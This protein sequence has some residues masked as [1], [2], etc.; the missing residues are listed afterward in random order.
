MALA[1]S[2]VEK[3][4]GV[5]RPKEDYEVDPITAVFRIALLSFLE[6]VKI[7][8]YNKAIFFSHGT[9]TEKGYRIMSRDS[10]NDLNALHGIIKV[11]LQI[12]PPKTET[13]Q[14]LLFTQCKLGLEQLK[15]TYSSDAEAGTLSRILD[16][17]MALIQAELDNSTGPIPELPRESVWTKEQLEVII[18]QLKVIIVCKNEQAKMKMIEGIESQL[19]AKDILYFEKITPAKAA[20]LPAQEGQAAPAH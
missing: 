18:F 4:F 11:A 10:S 2:I 1:V 19:D 5:P 12:L 8:F 20:V 16:E 9:V 17:D 13:P 6:R 15:K 3:L 14:R 7:G